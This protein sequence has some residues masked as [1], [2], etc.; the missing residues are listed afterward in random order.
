V[1]EKSGWNPEDVAFLAQ[2]SVDDFT[3]LFKENSGLRLRQ[4]IRAALQFG[5]LAG[6]DAEMKTVAERATE[7]LRSIGRESDINARRV[8]SYGIV[9]NHGDRS[10]GSA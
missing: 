10:S 9:V 7:A 3:R 1:S 6:A 4:M 5:A 8:R 2:L